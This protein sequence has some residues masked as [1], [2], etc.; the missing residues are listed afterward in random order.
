MKPQRPAVLPFP[1]ERVGN[2]ARAVP[3]GR[4]LVVRMR[5]PDVGTTWDDLT[6]L[7]FEAWCWRD[8][9]ALDRVEACLRHLS[10]EV[11]REWR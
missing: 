11:E 10:A 3:A 1:I 9:E 7:A 6:R 2:R 8:P 5:E 4:G